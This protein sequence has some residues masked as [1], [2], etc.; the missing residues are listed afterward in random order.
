MARKKRTTRPTDKRNDYQS[1]DRSKS[2]ERGY[3]PKKYNDAAWYTKNQQLSRDAG[4]FAFTWPTGAPLNLRYVPIGQ[5]VIGNHY[6]DGYDTTKYRLPG[7]MKI[8]F[9]PIVGS[10]NDATTPVNVAANNVYA[11]VRHANSGHANY[12][13]PDLMLYLLAMDYV[14]MF[15]SFMVR[16]YGSMLYYSKLNR[17][18]PYAL[19]YA[20]G[21]DYNDIQKHLSDLRFYINQCA[22][23]I[24]ALNVPNTFDYYKRHFWMCA[25]VY[26]D[27]DSPKSQFYAFVPTTLGVFEEYEGKGHLK[28]HSIYGP[29]PDH[30]WTFDDLVNI[31]DEMLNPILAS[32]DMNIMSG[33]ILK[34]YGD[35]NLF[36][37]NPIAETYSIEPV[38]DEETLEEIHNCTMWES[39]L[40]TSSELVTQDVNTGALYQTSTVR[41]FGRAL[42]QYTIIDMASPSP[43]PDRVLTA[44]RLAS[45]LTH[46]N[47]A[48]G[49]YPF[50]AQGYLETVGTEVVSNCSIITIDDNGVPK[51]YPISKSVV[52]DA[53]NYN[54]LFAVGVISKFNW[55]PRVNVKW[56]TG[57]GTAE[58]PA[59]VKELMFYE[60]DNYAIMD[61]HDL[62]KTHE[63]CLLSMFNVPQR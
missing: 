29:S 45:I 39:I 62:D 44:T 24:S 59:D 16:V 36:K 63:T 37:I 57:S 4:N 25:H 55:H 34:A 42:E 47:F 12:D 6:I 35:G 23:K 46:A 20:Y 2:K 26:R 40:S 56:W 38:Y 54:D 32:E 43:T 49:S 53:G 15:Y 48:G 19:E 51:R 21:V 50:P 17:H 30:L 60:M 9:S 41:Q 52:L 7:V 31:M 61:T 33:D 22:V 1:D 10:K 3:I 5:E 14:Y 27:Q 28:H 18:L 8:G 58:S 13:A 11:F